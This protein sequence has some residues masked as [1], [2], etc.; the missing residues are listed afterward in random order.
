LNPSG[1]KGA[2]TAIHDA[3]ALANWI[4][5]LK[6]KDYSE[7]GPIFKEYK[8]ERYPIA[9]EAFAVSQQLRNI[10]GKNLVSKTT[11]QIFL[12]MPKWLWRLAM[13]KGAR[14]RP[15]VSFLP[16]VEDNGTVKAGYQPSLH[17]TLAIIKKRAAE[18]SNNKDGAAAVA[19]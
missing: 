1:G 3:I 17:K 11:R 9:K 13:S 14:N 18:V 4:C 19:V 15:Q 7:L 2:V 16:Q 5:T 8:A 12:H 10:G 6:S